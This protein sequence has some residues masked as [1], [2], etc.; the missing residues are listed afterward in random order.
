MKTFQGGLGFCYDAIPAVFLGRSGCGSLEVAW[1]TNVLIDYQINGNALWDGEVDGVGNATRQENLDALSRL[2]QLWTFRQIS[3]RVLPTIADDA[4]RKLT[5]ARRAKRGAIIAG[6]ANALSLQFDDWEEQDGRGWKVISVD[7]PEAQMPLFPI[8][9]AFGIDQSVW[10]RLP[11][12]ADRKL[13]LEALA[14]NIHVFLTT[15]AQILRAKKHFRAQ[16]LL[17]AS[18][19]MLMRE[20]A[21]A[22]V[23][24]FDGGTTTHSPCPF[25]TTPLLFPDLQRM[26]SVMEAL[27]Q[28][29]D[30]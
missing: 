7:D 14:N 15:D 29:S 13:L 1:D 3:F 8:S 5:E 19:S 4:R 12:G 18:P 28:E 16:K 26:S 22:G 25:G 10:A 21:T 6:L 24:L 20:L 2:L 11:A 27:D 17:I 9:V 30:D 23:T